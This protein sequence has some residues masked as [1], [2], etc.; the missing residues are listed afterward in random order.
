MECHLWTVSL[1]SSQRFLQFCC[2]PC[3]PATIFVTFSLSPMSTFL[4]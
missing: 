2:R 3:I 1:H 4:W